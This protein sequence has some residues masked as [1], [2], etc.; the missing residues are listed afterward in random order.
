MMRPPGNKPAAIDPCQEVRV[1]SEQKL[2][3]LLKRVELD[4]RPRHGCDLQ[5]P[6][7]DSHW[8]EFHVMSV[9]LAPFF[10]YD[11]A[12]GDHLSIEI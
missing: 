1:A 7:R 9:V 8:C 4:H 3:G 6:W 5:S 11:P 10:V 12:L 2:Q